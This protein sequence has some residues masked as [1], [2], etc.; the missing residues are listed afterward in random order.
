MLFIVNPAGVAVQFT[1]VNGPPVTPVI[2][3]GCKVEATV[4]QK[5]LPV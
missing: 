4:W 1:T 5:G 2:L 3:T